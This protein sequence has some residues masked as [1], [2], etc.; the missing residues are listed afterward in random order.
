MAASNCLQPDVANKN[1]MNPPPPDSTEAPGLRLRV[2]QADYGDCLI[3]EST[4][5]FVDEAARHPGNSGDG[6]PLR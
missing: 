4:D 3:L 6:L 2:I 1:I 5:L